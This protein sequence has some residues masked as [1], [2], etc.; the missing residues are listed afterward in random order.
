[1]NLYDLQVLLFKAYKE[2]RKN[3]RNT[4][5]QLKFEAELETNLLRLAN[6][7]WN[8]TYELSSSICFVSKRPVAREIIAADFRDRVVHHLLYE[9]IYS[10][11]DRQF[12]YDSYSCRVGK[13]TLFGIN[14]AKGFVRAA[15]DDFRK[16]CYVLRLDISGFFMNINRQILWNQIMEG[17]EKTHYKNVPD[18]DLANFLIQ[19][20]VFDEPLKHA[21]FKGSE[22][23]WVTLPKNKSLKNSPPGCGLP[24][25]NLT[26]QL[27]GNIYLNSLDHYIKRILKI[28]SY[29][30]Y[31]DDMVFVH[32]N[33]NVLLDVIGEVRNFLSDKLRLTLH[34][35]KIYLQP[36]SN[37][38]SFL[39]A[40]ILPWRMY[41]SRRT[42]GYFRECLTKDGTKEQ[43]QSYHGYFSH[44]DF[45][46]EERRMLAA[47][48]L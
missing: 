22:S 40:F 19:K 46:K 47:Y 11:F 44:F 27:F 1:M 39:G 33:K 43:L 16:N 14:R 15:S 37:G 6:D 10:I 42:V 48:S 41:P 24:I 5:N 32:S 38:F 21:R 9:W 23:D 30:R 18:K 20:F 3:K 4:I 17:L 36:V 26:S 7:L 12:I 29:G 35:N 34:P 45:Y 28:K 25:G 2:A 31:V 8:K 13:G